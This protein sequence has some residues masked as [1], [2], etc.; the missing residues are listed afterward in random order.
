M[1]AVHLT[2]AAVH[3][4]AARVQRAQR[5]IRRLETLGE[6]EPDLFG[7]ALELALDARLGSLQDGMPGGGADAQ[8]AGEQRQHGAPRLH[9]T[10]ALRETTLAQ[11]SP[12]F[13]L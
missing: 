12:A 8:H 10:I 7:R 6:V 13:A 5:A 11:L 3:L 2:V 4:R 9:P 1:R